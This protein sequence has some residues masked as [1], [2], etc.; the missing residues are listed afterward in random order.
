MLSV[1]E[2]SVLKLSAL[3]LRQTLFNA[4]L[5]LADLKSVPAEQFKSTRRGR[6]GQTLIVQRLG[7]YRELDATS[8][9]AASRPVIGIVQRIF[10]SK[11]FAQTRTILYK[12]ALTAG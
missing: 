8:R 9:L 4:D 11:A 12:K 6:V 10:A 2:L 3:K 7:T 1:L 5:K